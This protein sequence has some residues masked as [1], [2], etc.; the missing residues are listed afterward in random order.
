MNRDLSTLSWLA[1]RLVLAVPVVVGVTTLTFVL[2]H[3]APG[4]PIYVLAG[5]GGSPAY[6]AEMRGK[7]GLDRPLP[8]Q[9]SRFVMAVATGDL[10]HS[11]MFQSPVLSLLISHGAASMLLGFSALVLG[12]VGGFGLGALSALT[13]SGLLDGLIRGGASLAYAAPVFWT[14]QIFIFVGSVTL[15]WLPVGGMTTAREPLSGGPLL[16]DIARHLLLP[17]LTLSLPFGAIV[18]RV[19][20]A[21][22]IEGLHDSYVRALYAHGLSTTRVVTRHVIPNA[23]VPVTALIAQHA[24]EIAA[25]AALTEAL[26]GWP[27]IGYLVLHASLHRDYPLVTAA[28]IVISAS[29]VIFTALGDAATAWLDPRIGLR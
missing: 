19:S 24:A 17:S 12:S 1:R 27:G 26:F 5:D 20:R 25:G 22:I 18:A 16:A 11:F 4:D 10:G 15:G 29:V 13:R 23:L 2:I 8:E 21:A 28:F 9:Y 14:G 6:Y 7:F 3:L